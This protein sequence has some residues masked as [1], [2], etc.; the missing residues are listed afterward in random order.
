[1]E[2]VFSKIKEMK[3]DEFPVREVP[4]ILGSSGCSDLLDFLVDDKSLAAMVVDDNGEYIG[5]ITLRH[6][7]SL[8][9]TK[10][11]EI[12][13]IFSRTHVLSCI[14]ALDLLRS[15]IPI[16]KDEDTVEKIATLMERYNTVFLPRSTDR[17]SKVKGLIFL[18]D[19]M[20]V[21]KDNWVGAC[22]DFDE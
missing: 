18:A 21:L 5:L 20:K 16:V 4:K 19:I 13:E 17:K 3:A 2:D 7:L 22:M 1:M 14:T 10:H 8:I 9:S 12:I 11:T 15:D 6:L